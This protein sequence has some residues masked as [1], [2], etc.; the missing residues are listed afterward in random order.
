MTH[1]LDIA[2]DS[3][4]KKLLRRLIDDIVDAGGFVRLHKHFEGAFREYEKEVHQTPGFWS[5]TE[6]AVREA[7]LIR[8]ARIYDQDHRAL[9][10]LTLLHTIGHHAEFFEDKAV[11]RRV[12][13]AYAEEFQPGSHLI[14]ER[15]LEKDIEAVSAADPLVA[16]VIRWRHNFGAHL[17][18]KPILRAQK[19][20]WSPLTRDDV[21]E[22]VDRA[23]TI[24]N[25]YLS[26][27]EGASYSRKII[28]EESHD[29][30]FKMLRLGLEKFEDD[31][32]KQ[33]G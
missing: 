22:L 11:L 9:S 4:L 20:T 17:S 8:L 12:S 15:Q 6:K 14:D 3:D 18:V 19:H 21:F 31:I 13:Q 30:L 7:S 1:P 23:F 26:S 24:F 16:K 2:D 33:W 27:F 29:F 25:R 10:L 28:G 5:F 32:R